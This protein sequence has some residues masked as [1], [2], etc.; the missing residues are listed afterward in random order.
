MHCILVTVVRKEHSYP[1]VVHW[2]FSGL[3]FCHLEYME[4]PHPQTEE[5]R[6]SYPWLEFR[7]RTSGNCTH[8]DTLGDSWEHAATLRALS[9]NTSTFVRQD[10][11]RPQQELHPEKRRELFCVWKGHRRHT[12]NEICSFISP[13]WKPAIAKL[14]LLRKQ[15]GSFHTQTH[16]LL[17]C[18]CVSVWYAWV[19]VWTHVWEHTWAC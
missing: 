3:I 19:Y 18:M 12:V 11:S 13:L 5:P 2:D 7:I 6:L 15:P 14:L 1:V 4:Q 8:V 10:T 9:P 17:F 16:L